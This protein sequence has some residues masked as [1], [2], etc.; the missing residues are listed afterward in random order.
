MEPKKPTTPDTEIDQKLEFR[1]FYE[2]AADGISERLGVPV[3]GVLIMAFLPG[4]LFFVAHYFCTVGVPFKGTVAHFHAWTWMV[5]FM[6]IAAILFVYY[7]THTLKRLFPQIDIWPNSQP[8]QKYFEPLTQTLNNQNFIYSG[9]FF[10]ALNTLMG[11]LFGVPYSTIAAQMSIY[12]GFFLVGFIC[13]LATWGIYGV[14]RTINVLAKENMIRLDY[15]AP[16]GCGGTQ[17]LG[18]AFVKFGAVTLIMGVMI[19]VYILSTWWIHSSEI[20]HPPPLVMV[21]IMAWVA[22]PYILS[23]VVLAVP[24]ILV[25]RVLV[26]YKLHKEK[27]FATLLAENRLLLRNDLDTERKKIIEENLERLSTGRILLHHMWT[28]P[29]GKIQGLQYGTVF[30]GNVF[31]TFQSVIPISDEIKQVINDFLSTQ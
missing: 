28:W 25:N 27:E 8:S 19:S 26:D 7:A 22:F 23:T 6:I 21:A 31:I 2:A 5:G 29:F 4:A 30:F 1:P 15:T 10:G 24:A 18:N 9:L 14:L 20:N 13:G 12:I 17:F 16:D 3:F 11:K